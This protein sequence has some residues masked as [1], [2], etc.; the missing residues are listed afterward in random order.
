MSISG[1]LRRLPAITGLLPHVGCMPQLAS[2]TLPHASRSFAAAAAAVEGQ[3]QQQ[4]VALIQG[5]SRGLGLEY[6]RQLLERDGQ[7]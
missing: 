1:A 3:T 5:A 6:T 2:R 4:R 7:R